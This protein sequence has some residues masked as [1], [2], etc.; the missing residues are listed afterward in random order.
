MIRVR[1]TT[2]QIESIA[3]RRN[4]YKCATSTLSRTVKMNRDEARTFQ[5]AASLAQWKFKLLMSL[6]TSAVT[7]AGDL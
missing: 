7:A 5:G 2:T 6:A 4:M 1:V 3:S